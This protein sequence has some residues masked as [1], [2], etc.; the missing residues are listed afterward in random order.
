M[1][2]PFDFNYYL[3]KQIVKKITPDLS[4]AKFLFSES[5]KSFE[6]LKKR[7][8]AM[9]FDD[10]NANS[11]I[12]DIQDIILE[13]VRAEMLLQG[14]SASGNYSHEAEV[15]FLKNL[16]FSENEIIFINQL[17]KARNGI[18][19]YG[20]LFDKDYAKKCFNFLIKIRKKIKL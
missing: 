19:Y 17:R 4:R 18:N 16:N 11:I 14:Y 15:S 10:F 20:N 3:K 6:G 1:M 7:V 2:S 8:E 13:R 5:E 12:K 9:G